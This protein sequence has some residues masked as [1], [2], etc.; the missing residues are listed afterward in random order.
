[1]NVSQQVKKWFQK[2]ETER[3]LKQ[4][5]P[6]TDEQTEQWSKSLAQKVEDIRYCHRLDL[7]KFI[8]NKIIFL[9]I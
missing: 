7:G 9:M 2:R 6:A 8:L 4:D 1:V 3:F 5:P